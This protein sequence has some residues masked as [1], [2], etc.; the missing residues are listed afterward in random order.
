MV[1][2]PVPPVTEVSHEKEDFGA[3]G[4]GETVLMAACRRPRKLVVTE[5]LEIGTTSCNAG[6][7]SARCAQKKYVRF[8][9]LFDNVALLVQVPAISN[10]KS[11]GTKNELRMQL[12]ACSG[13]GLGVQQERGGYVRVRSESP[14]ER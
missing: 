11:S 8:E 6:T 7:D 5:R 14:T 4:A 12:E 13:P 9:V 3:C 2:I 1:D 10:K